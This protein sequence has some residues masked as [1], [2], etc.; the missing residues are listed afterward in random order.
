M[1]SF[2]KCTFQISWIPNWVTYTTWM[3]LNIDKYGFWTWS[4][5]CVDDHTSNFFKGYS[6]LLII[7]VKKT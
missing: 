1:N 7:F 4:G 5:N 2:L 6:Y 3:T